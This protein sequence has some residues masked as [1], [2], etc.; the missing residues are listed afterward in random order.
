MNQAQLQ[1]ASV[2]RVNICLVKPSTFVHH[3]IHNGHTM[4]KVIMLQ[5]QPLQDLHLSPDGSRR[6]FVSNMFLLIFLFLFFYFSGIT[7]P[8]VKSCA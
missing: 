5:D 6:L 7:S 1:D 2:A 8:D 3:N 4:Y